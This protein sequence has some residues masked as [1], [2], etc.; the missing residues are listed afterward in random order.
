MGAGKGLTRLFENGSL[1]S[2]GLLKVSLKRMHS[3][4]GRGIAA[5]LQR[6]LLLSRT[7]GPLKSETNRSLVRCE[8]GIQF[9]VLLLVAAN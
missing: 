6:M 8:N 7:I 1:F 2:V 3:P 9:M 4:G 5:T